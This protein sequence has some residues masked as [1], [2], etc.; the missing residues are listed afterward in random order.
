MKVRLSSFNNFE[1]STSRAVAYRGKGAS[2]YSHPESIQ[3]K[4]KNG[5]HLQQ[6]K[7][8]EDN[9][10]DI[11]RP[12]ESVSF[13]GSAVS[14]GDAEKT[15]KK[16]SNIIAAAAFGA[17]AIGAT[18][19]LIASKIKKGD[20]DIFT[21]IASNKKF[22][23]VLDFAEQNETQIKAALALGLAGILKPIC[24]LAMPG[25]EKEDKQFTATKNCI[26]AFLG[27]ILSCAILNPISSG[28]NRFMDNPAEFLGEKNELVQRF[29]ED[30]KEVFKLQKFKDRW[31]SKYKMNESGAFKTTYKNALGIFV[32]PAKAA[33]T[34]ALMPLVLK[35]LFG[36]TKKKKDKTNEVPLYMEPLYNPILNNVAKNDSPF[37]MFAKKGETK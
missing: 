5:A 10:K 6:R 34:I 2:P 32:A 25:A 17:V 30:K 36:D 16:K 27:Y 28:V 33:L 3:T 19:L 12:T 24:V 22:N 15:G 29:A 11:N 9:S 20:G 21:R 35:F 31:C 8:N 14:E 18:A 1:S 23:A 7:I 26:S 4:D 37:N 13:S